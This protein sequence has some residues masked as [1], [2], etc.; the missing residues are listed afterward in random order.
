MHPAHFRYNSFHPVAY[1]P[2]HGWL[3]ADTFLITE[4]GATITAPVCRGQLVGQFQTGHN[5]EGQRPGA[6][7]DADVVA[8]A[9]NGQP[10]GRLIVHGTI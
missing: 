5:A 6:G 4:V 3:Q 10:A 9:T 7:Y 1:L 8:T 2:A